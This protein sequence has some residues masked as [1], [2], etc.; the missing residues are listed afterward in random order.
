[1]SSNYVLAHEVL[2]LLKITG[3][4]LLDI[5]DNNI[6]DSGMRGLLQSLMRSTTLQELRIDGNHLTRRSIRMLRKM[7]K[8]KGVR[9]QMPL[10]AC[11]CLDCKNA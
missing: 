3:I 4:R 1:M 5:S 10:A 8:T 11:P 9:V 2:G 6:S 7:S